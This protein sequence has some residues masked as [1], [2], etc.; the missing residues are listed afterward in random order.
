M[1]EPL[2]LLSRVSDELIGDDDLDVGIQVGRLGCSGADAALKPSRR[3]ADQYQ[4]RNG[5]TRI[6]DLKT[7]T[8]PV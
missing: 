7:F 3:C 4:S 1:G 6:C 2:S 8:Y 5:R